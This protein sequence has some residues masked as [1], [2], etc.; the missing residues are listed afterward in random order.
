MRDDDHVKTNY[1]RIYDA[2]DLQLSA[3]ALMFHQIKA[4]S[5]RILVTKLM[6]IFGFC[7]ISS[8]FA[9]TQINPMD[10]YI[11]IFTYTWV[12]YATMVQDAIACCS[13]EWFHT[14]RGFVVALRW[15]Q[16]SR[17]LR[18]DDPFFARLGGRCLE[19]GISPCCWSFWQL[20]SIGLR[21]TSLCICWALHGFTILSPPTSSPVVYKGPFFVKETLPLCLWVN[22]PCSSNNKSV[23]IS[24]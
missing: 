22:E 21:M 7:I 12:Q 8:K 17:P 2:L 15:L 14:H 1:W 5:M 23:I 4:T 3:G 20:D 24:F 18:K 13:L 10:L 19:Q 9:Q 16:Q 6:F 11:Y